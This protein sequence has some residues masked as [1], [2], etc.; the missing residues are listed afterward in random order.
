VTTARATLAAA[1]IALVAACGDEE[2][3]PR[4]V[5]GERAPT[6]E[7]PRE[8][9]TPMP[10]GAPAPTEPRR[11]M[12]REVC[13][14]EAGARLAPTV[15]PG[16]PE[17]TRVAI[18]ASSG[19]L[20]SLVAIDGGG[21]VELTWP[22]PRSPTMRRGLFLNELEEGA[23][24]ALEMVGED[25]ALLVRAGACVDEGRS[26]QCLYARAVFLDR[27]GEGTVVSPPARVA[28]PSAPSTLRVSATEDRV[29][30]ARSHV[31]AAPALDTFLVDG[32]SHTVRASTRPLG[33]GLDLERGPVEIL[34]LATSGGSFAA[35]WRQGAQEA[36]DSAVHLTTGLDEH[37]VPELQEALV[38]E[39]MTLFAGAIVM[40]VAFE[41][42][43]PSWLR[44]GFDGE[45]RGEP[46]PLAAGEAVPI[47]F[48]DRRVARLDGEPPRSVEIRDG[49][50]HASAPPVSIPPG[51]R[52]ADLARFDGGFLLAA[53]EGQDVRLATIRCATPGAGAGDD[54][55]APAR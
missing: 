23:L 54:N 43:E 17:G 50:G 47:P 30:V 25:V 13:T 6:V 38:V 9:A 41:F 8:P 40:I 4:E 55:G 18:A 49:A 51:A 39:S 10:T 20:T 32:P 7:A 53:L 19:E 48:S 36:D 27:G 35:L 33:E 37:A 46:R 1:A 14:L 24:F 11:G 44:L 45:L 15:P 28:M 2:R 31:G 16:R 52:A 42:S 21:T 34:A 3:G 29:L 26:A 5:P 22:D 12:A